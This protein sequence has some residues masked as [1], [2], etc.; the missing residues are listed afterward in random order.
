[1]NNVL[2]IKTQLNLNIFFKPGTSLHW[3]LDN[4]FNIILKSNKDNKI[5]GVGLSSM[6]IKYA[7]MDA[8]HMV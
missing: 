1:M 6:Y 4:K 8:P 2:K 7:L 3:V 5:H